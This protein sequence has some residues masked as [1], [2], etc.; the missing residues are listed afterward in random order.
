MDPRAQGISG[1]GLLG[2][3]GK[4]AARKHL[5]ALAGRF[6]DLAMS[7]PAD[8]APYG[9]GIHVRINPNFRFSNQT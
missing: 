8:V 3:H 5:P 1:G 4:V 7:L 6:Q 2:E 9:Q